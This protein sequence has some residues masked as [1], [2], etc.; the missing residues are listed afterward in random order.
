MLFTSPAVAAIIG[1]VVSM[2]ARQSGHF[3]FEPLDYDEVNEATQEYKEAIKVGYNLKRKVVLMSIWILSP[4]VLLVSPTLGGLLWEANS[5]SQLIENVG[6]IWLT[7][8]VIGLLF[9]TVHLFYLR[10]VQTGLVWMTKILTD[11]FNDI[12][13]Y[14]GAPLKLL[15]GELIDPRHAMQHEEKAA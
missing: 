1:W 13:L 14:H 2:V 12:I 8:G 10:D 5:P 11:P 6:L 3:F 7:V 15:Q 9:R 4:F